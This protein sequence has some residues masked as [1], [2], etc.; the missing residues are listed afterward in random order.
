MAENPKS[1]P[2]SVPVESL[3]YEEALKELEGIVSALETGEQTLEGSLN[4]FA[5]GNELATYCANLLNRAELQ[6]KQI[7]DEKL[8]PFSPSE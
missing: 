2:E 5:R 8:L 4:L 6:V 3:S 1:A 7:V